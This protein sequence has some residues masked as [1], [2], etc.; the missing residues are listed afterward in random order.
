MEGIPHYRSETILPK[1]VIEIIFSFDDALV[2]S[3][4]QKPIDRSTPR[5]FINGI[6]D[7]PF[8]LITPQRQSF[9]GVEMHPVAIKK[10][11]KIPCGSLLNQVTDLELINNDFTML[12]HKMVEVKTFHSRINIIQQWISSKLDPVHQQER[13]IADFLNSPNE[14]I[15]VKGLA[16]SSCYSS[17]QLNR[18]SQEYFGMS[19]EALISY[20]RY[21]HALRFMHYSNETLTRIAY[22]C[23]YYDQAHFNREFKNYTGLTP[24]DYRQ[25]KSMLAGHLYRS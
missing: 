10:L 14:A 11:L 4:N 7:I 1:G 24:G 6:N 21:L 25:S 19:T 20:K 17:R 12:W 23:H 8:E 18:K 2:F 3:K 15:S 16:S 9:F 22:E 13:S 5:C